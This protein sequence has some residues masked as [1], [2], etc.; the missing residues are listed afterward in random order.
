ME[1]CPTTATYKR[2][3]GLVGIDYNKCIGCSY[4]IMACPYDARD[5]LYNE[6]KA[7]LDKGAMAHEIE[8][9][10]LASLSSI[11]RQTANLRR[12]FCLRDREGQL[13]AGLTCSTAYGWLHVE[14]LWVADDLRAHGLGRKLM[15]AAEAFGRGYGC[16]GAWLDT[17]NAGARSFYQRLG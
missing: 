10:L 1:V 13:I 17:S 11:N 2:D 7:Y 3:D 6:L 12:T 9:E 15:E 5:M 8:R 4:C 16:H 14:T